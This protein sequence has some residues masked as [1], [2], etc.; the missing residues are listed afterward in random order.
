[1]N[2]LAPIQTAIYGALTLPFSRAS[3]ATY[4]NIGGVVQTAAVNVARTAHYVNGVLQP[5]LYESAATN[6]ILYSSDFSNPA[7][8]KVT[9][10]VT[11]GIADPA[12]GTAACTLTA[13]GASGS[14]VW[15]DRGTS[16]PMV[17]THS[18]W[19]K[20]R[21]GVDTIRLY[22][23]DGVTNTVCAVDAT[24]RRFSIAG[25]LSPLRYAALVIDALGDAVDV[26]NF[27]QEDGAVATSTIPT[28]S[29]PVTRAPDLVAANYPVYDSVPQG[30][31][32]PY[33][34]IG[35]MLAD[36]DL[37][38]TAA[39]TDAAINLHTWSATH[40]K[41]QSHAMLDFIRGRLDGQTLSGAWI[42]AEEFNEL[43]EDQGSTASARLYHGVARYQ[44][45]VG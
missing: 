5:P 7:W 15:Q 44:V 13:T 1:M 27:Q 18:V 38:L 21:T 3:T 4:V 12:G 34:A 2:N 35:E 9:C 45:R 19:L 17:R 25:P 6:N 41:S 36:P 20:R 43:M 42:C 11:T 28:T 31:A 16:S 33:I 30:V 26:W 40:G 8:T 24:W 37:E 10:T 29:E 22:A 14:Q 39:T 23:P 32:K